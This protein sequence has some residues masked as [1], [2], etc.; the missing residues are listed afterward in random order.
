VKEGTYDINEASSQ[1][2]HAFDAADCK[3][4]GNACTT[5]MANQNN[6]YSSGSRI[7]AF[8][9]RFQS[10]DDSGSDAQFVVFL[11]R[12]TCA[13][14]WEVGDDEGCMRREKRN[15]L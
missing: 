2:I 13:V 15:E 10:V 8:D 14:A 6:G 5:I 11:N 9:K 1:D 3:T 4:M 7:R 12:C